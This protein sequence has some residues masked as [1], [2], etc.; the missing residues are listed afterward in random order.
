MPSLSKS[1]RTT[2]LAPE[3]LY[4]LAGFV[5]A[6]GVSLSRIRLARR[7]GLEFPTVRVGKRA[8]VL[9]SQAIEYLLQLAELTEREKAA[10]VAAAK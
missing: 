3:R 5:K 7:A 8:F 10:K 4:S 2:Y 9:G 6:T 1:S